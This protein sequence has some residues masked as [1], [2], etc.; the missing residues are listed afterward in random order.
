[1]FE[2]CYNW[3]G[4]LGSKNQWPTCNIR[5]HLFQTSEE[6]LFGN[7][8]HGAAMNEFLDLIG[9]RVKLKEFEG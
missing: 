1:M 7:S 8:S 9:H 5:C 2:P 6:E 3:N 4:W